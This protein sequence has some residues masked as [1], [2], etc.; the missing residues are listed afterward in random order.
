MNQD[1]KI[2]LE[3]QVS[4]HTLPNLAFLFSTNVASYLNIRFHLPS[5]TAGRSVY[6]TLHTSC[7]GLNFG[8]LNIAQQSLS[9]IFSCLL[10]RGIWGYEISIE[11]GLRVAVMT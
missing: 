11:N 5:Q 9:A 2:G 6:G 8:N 10:H 3:R 7:L 1:F 4:D